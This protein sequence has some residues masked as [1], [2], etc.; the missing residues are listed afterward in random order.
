[1]IKKFTGEYQVRVAYTHNQLQ[2]AIGVVLGKDV[3]EA[4]RTSNISM[5]QR[6]QL[7]AITCFILEP[8]TMSEMN[9]AKIIQAAL[10]DLHSAGEFNYG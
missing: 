9:A 5:P 8:N 4:M 2:E 10:Y 1:M 3:A 7:A 6:V